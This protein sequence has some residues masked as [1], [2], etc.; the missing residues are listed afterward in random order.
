MCSKYYDWHLQVMV[1][2]VDLETGLEWVW[3]REKFLNRKF[4]MQEMFEKFEDGED[5]QLPPVSS[6]LSYLPLVQILL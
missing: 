6:L 3:S 1:H 2:V 5:W 4:V